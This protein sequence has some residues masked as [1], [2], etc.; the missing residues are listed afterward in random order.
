MKSS[1][2]LLLIFPIV[3]LFAG[4][5]VLTQNLYPLDSRFTPRTTTQAPKTTTQEQV[6]AVPVTQKEKAMPY[7]ILA[8]VLLIL[9]L[10]L[11][12]LQELSI[13]QQSLVIKLFEEVKEAA[14]DLNE[15]VQPVG[16]EASRSGTSKEKIKNLQDKINSLNKILSKGK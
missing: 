13:S 6:R 7:F 9:I 16:L 11:P 15:E 2:Y 8:S 14:D 5:M 4:F 1:Y 3:I 12:R 10:A